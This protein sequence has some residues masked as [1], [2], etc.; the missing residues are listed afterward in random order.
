MPELLPNPWPNLQRVAVLGLGRSGLA[1]ARLLSRFPLQLILSDASRSTP[2]PD[3][4]L[5]GTTLTLGQNTLGDAQL[6]VI[7]PGLPIDHPC[8][9]EAYLRGIELVS[10]LDLGAQLLTPHAGHHRNRR[11]NHH[12]LALCSHPP[13]RGF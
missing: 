12:N 11:K 7:S 1:V 10:E 13:A 8:V 3:F 9:K 5:P 2:P 6:A 4:M